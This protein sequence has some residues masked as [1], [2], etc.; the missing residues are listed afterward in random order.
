MTTIMSATTRGRLPILPEDWRR[1]GPALSEG[2]D[3]DFLLFD[4]GPDPQRGRY[5]IVGLR[6]A[7]HMLH[8]I[9]TLAILHAPAVEGGLG[10]GASLFVPL[11][12]DRMR[13]C[14][15]VAALRRDDRPFTPADATHLRGVARRVLSLLND[16]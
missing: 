7:S 12:G 2:L 1:M 16:R 5:T 13:H 3:A 15:H 11:N 6:S 10:I 4:L 9:E 14:G 8:F